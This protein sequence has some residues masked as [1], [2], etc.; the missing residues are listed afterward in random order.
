MG[1]A[2]SGALNFSALVGVYFGIFIAFAAAGIALY[3]FFT[4][5]MWRLCEK[6]YRPGW[7]ALIPFYNLYV[8]FA[9]AKMKLLYVV[10]LILLA[11]SAVFD[12]MLISA[13]QPPLAPLVALIP[14][15]IALAIIFARLS[16]G[17]AEAFDKG[18]LFAAGFFLL[19]AIF[20]PVLG[21]GK[22]R[23]FSKL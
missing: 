17:I 7:V 14:I 18:A 13:N 5:A 8:L 22:S 21:F 16:L 4:V 11:A 1:V 10:S 12:Y 19:P 6:L 23:Y 2:F 20:L 15:V 3:V 9:A